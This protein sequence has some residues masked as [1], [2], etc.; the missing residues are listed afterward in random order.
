[1]FI[2]TL[3]NQEGSIL[4]LTWIL[5]P[6]LFCIIL[7]IQSRGSG[8]AKRSVNV[9]ESWYTMQDIDVVYKAIEEVTTE[10][11]KEDERKRSSRS[12]LLRLIGAFTGRGGERFV[13]NTRI[14][15]RLYKINDFTG[16]IFFELTE[17]EGEG[18]VVNVT[19]NSAIKPK[20]A[21]FKASQPVKIPS[22]PTGNYCPACGKPVFPKFN[23]CPY[24]GEKIINESTV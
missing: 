24:C 18:T 9:N 1:M 20:I 21:K 17:V 11:R 19:Y 8:E 14:F 12:S 2:K 13:T 7:M 15:P 16:P 3:I 23:L 6:I 10:W 4:D 22:N 5:L